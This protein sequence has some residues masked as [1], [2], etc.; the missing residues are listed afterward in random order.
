MATILG[1]NKQSKCMYCGSGTYGKGCPY[2]PHRVHVH[3]DDPKRCIYCAATN[4]GPG[5][6]YNPFAR[7]HIHGVEY[8]ML[9]KE[10]VHRSFMTALFLTR[11]N[12]PIEETPAFKLNVIDKDGRRIKIPETIEEKNAL[13]PIDVYVLKLRRM[14]SE[15]RI[16][17]LNASV[18]IEILAG[19][20][21][22]KEF[23]SE[24]Y[25]KEIALKKKIECLANDYKYI[26]T[27]AVGSG[28][29]MADVEHMFVEC[30]IDV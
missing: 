13:T 8:N 7:T 2:S 26:M 21:G 30:L 5:C 16:K 17:M 12:E 28:I 22:E 3:V 11:L 10:N 9:T 14:V 27:E 23:I 6:I 20:K 29:S 1:T 18:V 15:S 4:Y 25:E 19:L 24:Q